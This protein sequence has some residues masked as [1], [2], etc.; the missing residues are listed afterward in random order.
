MSFFASQ[1]FDAHELTLKSC[2]R[3]LDLMQI[4]SDANRVSDL[5]CQTSDFV[6]RRSACACDRANIFTPQSPYH[7]RKKHPYQIFIAASRIFGAGIDSFVS[8]RRL[9]PRIVARGGDYRVPSPLRKST[10]LSSAFFRL[11]VSHTFS[12]SLKDYLNLPRATE[13]FRLFPREITRQTP[14]LCFE[15][16]RVL[17]DPNFSL[18]MNTHPQLLNS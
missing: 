4:R 11:P 8:H 6:D 16:R 3:V 5:R 7:A 1:H 15:D 10:S 17:R 2:S 13:D 9:R 12:L 18:T 14:V